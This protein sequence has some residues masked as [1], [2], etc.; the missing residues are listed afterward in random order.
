LVHPRT[1]EKGTLVITEGEVGSEFFVIVTGTAA[2]TIGGDKLE[3]LTAGD[4]F[5]EISLLDGG[6]R[7]ASVTA[8]SK[9]DLLVLDRHD[10]NEMLEAA[11]P[12]VTPKLLQVVGE[13]MRALAQHDGKPTIGF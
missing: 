6:E 2:A 5:G 9:L 1:V 8:T 3:D 13:R 4:F 12:E 11:M 7:L 10:F